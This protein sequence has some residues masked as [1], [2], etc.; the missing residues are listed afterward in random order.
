MKTQTVS[1][2]LANAFEL[3]NAKGVP[4]RTTFTVL[5]VIDGVADA[6]P[7][8]T[9]ISLAAGLV[10][11]TNRADTFH[12]FEIETVTV[13]QLNAERALRRNL[14]AVIDYSS[15]NFW[16]DAATHQSITVGLA[17]A[18]LLLTRLEASLIY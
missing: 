14:L 1:S 17:A 10:E 16:A 18:C 13:S 15:S 11:M 3:R 4:A 9:I 7:P 8:N 2:I 5:V 6:A 12:K